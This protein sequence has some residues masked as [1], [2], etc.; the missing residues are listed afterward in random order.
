[1]FNKVILV[2]RLTRDPELRYTP[3]GGV[4]VVNFG[5]AVERPFTNKQGERDVD[6]INVVVWRRQAENCA[7]HLSKGALVALDGRIQ[8]R[9]FEDKEGNRRN[10][11]EVVAENV[12]FLKWPNNQ[13]QNRN[14]AAAATDNEFYGND[15][16]DEELNSPSSTN[17]LG[18]DDSSGDFGLGG[19]DYKVEDDDVPF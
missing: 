14:T 16:A 4:A 8:S 10:V 6:F 5:L 1:M 3:G 12:Q 18:S 15:E 7:N 2:G 9:S 19:E 17:T 11:V 13:S